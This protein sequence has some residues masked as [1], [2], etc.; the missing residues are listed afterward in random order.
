MFWSLERKCYLLCVQNHVV[1][2]INCW[3][4]YWSAWILCVLMYSL[5]IVRVPLF[6]GPAAT[7]HHLLFWI[8]PGMDQTSQTYPE[9]RK[10]N[11]LPSHHMSTRNF[12]KRICELKYISLQFCLSSKLSDPASNRLFTSTHVKKQRLWTEQKRYRYISLPFKETVLH[13]F[14]SFFPRLFG[15]LASL[16]WKLVILD[17]TSDQISLLSPIQV[18]MFSDQLLYVFSSVQEIKLIL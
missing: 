9:Q 12:N 5:Y 17:N 14:Q 10:Y 4:L 13:S 3:R 16:K 15:L 7:F 8:S 6:C 18:N 2:Y 11:M 1:R